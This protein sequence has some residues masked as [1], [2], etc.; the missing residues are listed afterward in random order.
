MDVQA[1]CKPDH[2]GM[3]DCTVFLLGAQ[4]HLEGALVMPEVAE[5][6]DARERPVP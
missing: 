5:L 2:A 4:A 6:A 3:S 1:H